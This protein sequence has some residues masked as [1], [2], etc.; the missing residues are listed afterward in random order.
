MKN[1]LVLN[2]GSSSIKLSLFENSTK[3][4][5]SGKL[6][7]IGTDKSNILFNQEEIFI[8]AENF[9][10]AVKEIFKFL[11]THNLKFDVIAHRIVHGGPIKKTSKVDKK[12]EQTIQDYIEFAPLHN[13]PALT[14][15]DNCKKMNKPQYVSFDTAFFSELPEVA[16]TYPIPLQISKKYH[17]KKYGFHGLS[18][19]FISQGLKGKTITCHLGNGCSITA[20]LNGKPLDTSM[21]LTPLEGLMMG[22]RSGDIDAGLVIYLSKKGYDVNKILNFESGL[23]AFSG[24]TDIRETLQNLDK[25]QIKLG[26]DIFIY[27]LVKYIGA[28]TAVLNGLDNL[29]FAGGIAENVPLLR[30]EICKNFKYINLELDKQKNNKNEELISSKSSKV[31]VYVRKTDEESEI[32]RE[33]YELT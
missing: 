16:S 19:R 15:I 25:P 9:S 2:T 4:I 17:L 3:K 24:K 22:S 12:V 5:F 18:H 29:V 6:E 32:A 31:N 14:V 13:Q 7:R 1:L 26:F 33:V 21:G 11:E 20:I 23:F 28:Y 8:K 27:R 10:Q 30:E